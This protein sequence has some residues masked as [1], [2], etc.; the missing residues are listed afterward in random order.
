MNNQ[1]AI[2]LLPLRDN[3]GQPFP[4][5]DWDWMTDELVAR[6]GGWTFDGRVEGAWRDEKSGQIYRDVSA[7]YVVVVEK[8]AMA[9]LF[10]FLGEVKTRFG[11]EALFV[12]LPK[13]EVHFI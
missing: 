2:F 5:S 4:A 6:F 3:S 13:T 12:E 10:S 1:K 9:D 7:R 11:Q 8:P